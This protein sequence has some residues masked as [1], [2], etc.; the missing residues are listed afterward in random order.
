MKKGFIGA[1]Q[2]GTLSGA[3]EALKIAEKITNKPGIDLEGIFYSTAFQAG[4]DEFL[5]PEFKDELATKSDFI[6]QRTSYIGKEKSDSIYKIVDTA[7]STYLPGGWERD[8]EY[9]NIWHLKS[10]LGELL[11]AMSLRSS[12][13]LPS[14]MPDFSE[15]ESQLPSE[16]AQPISLLLSTIVNIQ[17][18]SPIQ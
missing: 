17:T 9:H 12:L 7:F 16:L 3:S 14:A 13:L 10:F 1:F 4:I 11:V 18:P 15:A 6:E 8:D 5:I 2:F